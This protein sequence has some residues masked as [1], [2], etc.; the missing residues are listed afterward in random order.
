[1]QSPNPDTDALGFGKYGMNSLLEGVN[2][3]DMTKET[4]CLIQ[5]L[6]S[7]RAPV[8]QLDLPDN[9]LPLGL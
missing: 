4:N 5:G 3:K 9:P 2:G 6:Y 7:R 8:Q 1:M